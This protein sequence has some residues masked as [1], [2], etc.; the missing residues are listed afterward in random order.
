MLIRRK[1]SIC[2]RILKKN[3]P[4]LLVDYLLI[5]RR[6]CKQICTIEDRQLLGR[7]HA[8]NASTRQ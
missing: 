5:F 8:D 4:V 6:Y 1:K 2:F 3:K 7:H